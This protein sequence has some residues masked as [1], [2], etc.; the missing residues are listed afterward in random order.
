MRFGRLAA[1]LLGLVCLG[2][3]VRVGPVWAQAGTARDEKEV[4]EPAR[5]QA[6][7]VRL[8]PK[9]L[10]DDPLADLPGELPGEAAGPL[11]EPDEPELFGGPGWE[12]PVEGRTPGLLGTGNSDSVLDTPLEPDVD[13]E[14]A[15]R[16][17]AL[18]EKG[19][20]PAARALGSGALEPADSP[21]VEDGADLGTEYRDPVEW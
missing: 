20:D 9:E 7:G 10:P 2:A 14:E 5:A 13:E 21:F 12:D 16:Q 3:A 6:D 1:A 15:E 17:R 4:R 11:E 19:G 8:L 18:A